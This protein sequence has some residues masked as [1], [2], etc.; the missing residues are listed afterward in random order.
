[1]GKPGRNAIMLVSIT[2]LRVFRE[3]YWLQE[4]LRTILGNK[5]ER[6]KKTEKVDRA[7]K[8]PSL[9]YDYTHQQ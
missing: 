2:L 4:G 1:M 7:M 3:T 9:S 6:E 8:L 5:E